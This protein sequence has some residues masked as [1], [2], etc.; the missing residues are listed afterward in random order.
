MCGR[1]GEAVGR[2]K[3][4]WC[5]IDKIEAEINDRKVIACLLSKKKVETCWQAGNTQLRGR[6]T[7]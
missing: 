2:E 1:K 5:Q 4:Q 7:A 6:H 3:Q